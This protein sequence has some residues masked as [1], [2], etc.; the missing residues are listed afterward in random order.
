MF[1][2]TSSS[3]SS[4]SSADEKE[5]PK[6]HSNNNNNKNENI[7]NILTQ[8]A[9][10]ETKYSSSSSSSSTTSESENE[11]EN[12]P[13]LKISKPPFH[14]RLSIQSFISSASDASYNVNEINA[15]LNF[16]MEDFDHLDDKEDP[17]DE[18]ESI[19]TFKILKASTS[20]CSGST[21]DHDQ[22]EEMI[23]KISETEKIDNNNLT[24]K[25]QLKI[26]HQLSASSFETLYEPE[27]KQLELVKTSGSSSSS[28]STSTDEH[29][30]FEDHSSDSGKENVLEE[31]NDPNH[32]FD[33]SSSSS[34]NTSEK[35]IENKQLKKLNPNL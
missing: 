18:I 29:D 34:S 23:L 33:Y 25:S 27:M 32:I 30:D 9:I 24:E 15:E 17:F 1:A 3:S 26:H 19:Q 13:K 4:V 31:K 28:S 7:E 22:D 10:Y 16:D 6:D 35:E 20:T 21:S 14:Q 12:N 11:D 8:I 2:N 5:F